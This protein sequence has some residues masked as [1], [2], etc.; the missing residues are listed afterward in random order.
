M[1][2]S[3]FGKREEKKILCLLRKKNKFGAGTMCLQLHLAVAGGGVGG[4][5]SL[6]K[7]LHG[8]DCSAGKH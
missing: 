5:E 3:S 1:V 2:N 4:V 8:G 7:L 6:A